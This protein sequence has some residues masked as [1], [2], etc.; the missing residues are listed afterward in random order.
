MFLDAI[1][2]FLDGLN[3]VVVPHGLIHLEEAA[4]RDGRTVT[5]DSREKGLTN[6]ELDEIDAVVTASRVGNLLGTIILTCEPDQGR[7][8]I[9]LVPI[10]RPSVDQRDAAA[11]SLQAVVVLAKRTR[12]DPSRALWDRRSHL[13]H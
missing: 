8:V 13:R 10:P 11:D 12:C 5:E 3:S 6:Y 7:R 2:D 9:T 1:A 4:A